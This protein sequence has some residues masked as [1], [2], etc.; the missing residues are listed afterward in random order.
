MKDVC[1]SGIGSRKQNGKLL[2]TSAP[3]RTG[4]PIFD[5]VNITLFSSLVSKIDQHYKTQRAPFRDTRPSRQHDSQVLSLRGVVCSRG[6]S[7]L[8]S[9]TRQPLASWSE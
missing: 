8:P 2:Q 5:S 9:P 3:F 7:I 6:S 1:S 4:M